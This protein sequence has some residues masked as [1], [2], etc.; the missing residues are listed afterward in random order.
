MRL[1]LLLSGVFLCMLSVNAQDDITICNP[2]AKNGYW[3]F[4]GKD[5]PELDYPPEGKVEEGNYI[6]NRKEGIWI[7][8]H[9][10]GITPKLKGEYKNNRPYGKYSKFFSDGSLMEAGTFKN[11]HYVDT[12]FRYWEDGNIRFS[13]IYDADGESIVDSFFFYHENSCLSFIDVYRSSPRSWE[14]IVYSKD[15][16]NKVTSTEFHGISTPTGCGGPVN[17]VNPSIH[18]GS[19]DIIY[20]LDS[21]S[22][23]TDEI[24]V[25]Q[26][27]VNAKKH[28]VPS[29]HSVT[30]K[31]G[32]VKKNGYMKLYNKDDE[33]FL[34]GDFQNHQLW[35]GKVYVYDEDGILLRVK[36]YKN[37]QYHSD[38]Q[39]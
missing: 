13:G 32:Q 21:T 20:F 7:K 19:V 18:K 22:T 39:L 2:P 31:S 24:I 3:V 26:I 34:D 25:H 15:T 1:L 14:R 38:G 17:P 16:C 33:I 6:N 9:S 27:N 30:I 8:Y 29:T 10:D 4:L 37:G 12:L 23:G 35:N 28:S 36:V 11:N 5:R